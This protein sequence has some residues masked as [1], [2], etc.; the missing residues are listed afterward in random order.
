MFG[1]G[2]EIEMRVSGYFSLAFGEPQHSS[3]GTNGFA[4]P[5]STDL[6]QPSAHLAAHQTEIWEH[7][8]QHSSSAGR[9]LAAPSA[10]P[11]PGIT[12]AP[13][14]AGFAAKGQSEQLPC[15]S[16]LCSM[17]S[18]PR[19]QFI[20]YCH[21]YLQ[22]LLSGAVC[23]KALDV[24]GREMN[25]S[26]AS[27]QGPQQ[28]F[29]AHCQAVGREPSALDAHGGLGDEQTPADEQNN[30]VQ[31]CWNAHQTQH[32]PLLRKKL[33]IETFPPQ[34]LQTNKNAIKTKVGKADSW[35]KACAKTSRQHGGLR[36]AS[37]MHTNM[38][39]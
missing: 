35:E 22:G 13:S 5:W 7:W 4:T 29:K 6:W 27:W 31:A 37:H 21:K 26:P 36:A 39:V 1:L 11:T 23:R 17:T 34:G 16:H 15:T 8:V 30:S 38:P 28:N 10:S 24:S 25:Q 3:S 20:T 12:P 2:Q 33:R 18:S 32:P 9:S 19:G 14:G